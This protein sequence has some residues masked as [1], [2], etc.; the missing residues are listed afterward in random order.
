M[1]H[2]RKDISV[3]CL[4]KSPRISLDLPWERREVNQTSS[5][6]FFFKEMR[7]NTESFDS[8]FLS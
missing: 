3:G 8:L 7:L 2:L 5:R 6:D 1:F 4:C